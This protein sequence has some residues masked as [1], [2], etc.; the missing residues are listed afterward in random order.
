MTVPVTH[1]GD[2]DMYPEYTG[3]LL[4]AVAGQTK[5]PTSAAEAAPTKTPVPSPSA[6][7]PRG[8]A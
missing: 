6:S 2:I 7:P 3:V 4:S 1:A 5:L 8:I